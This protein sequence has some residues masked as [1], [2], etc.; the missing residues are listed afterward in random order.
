[1]NLPE[2]KVTGRVLTLSKSTLARNASLGAESVPA[3]RQASDSP[4]VPISANDALRPSPESDLDD[5]VGDYCREHGWYFIRARTDRRSTLAVGTP[6]YA[7]F[8]HGGRTLF[9]ELKRRGGKATTAQL[10]A[11]AHL[12]KLGHMAEVVDNWADALRFLEGL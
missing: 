10:A 11:I 5:K 3:A 7:I 8:A 9:L 6:D 4:G 12:R 1:M 2:I